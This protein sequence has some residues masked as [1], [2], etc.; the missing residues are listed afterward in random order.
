M[1]ID[2]FSADK[3]AVAK[4][5]AK[6]LDTLY[7]NLNPHKF[8]LNLD[9]SD[10]P[11]SDIDDFWLYTTGFLF[12][13][14]FDE[15]FDNL[16]GIEIQDI[17]N[18]KFII[19]NLNQKEMDDLISLAN[20]KLVHGGYNSLIPLFTVQDGE[21]YIQK[22]Q[23]NNSP[24]KTVASLILKTN[25]INLSFFNEGEDDP[26][27]IIHLI[28]NLFVHETPFV[29]GSNIS[30]VHGG[31]ILQVS[32]MWLR[33]FSEMF[34][35]EKRLSDEKDIIKVLETNLPLSRNY[36]EEQT[37]VDKALSFIKDCF[38]S[39][40]KKN[41]TYV[42]NFVKRRILYTDEFYSLSLDEKIKFIA[43]ICSNNK[44]YMTS[45][46]GEMDPNLIYNLQA[47]VSKELKRRGFDANLP[48]KQKENDE[49]KS[50]RQEIDEMT[51]KFNALNNKPRSLSGFEKKQLS[52]LMHQV[53]ALIKLYNSKLR[54]AQNRR[55]LEST[56][57]E[58]FEIEGLDNLNVEVAVNLVC[59]MGFNQLITSGFYEDL[60]KNVDF[61]NFSNE[62]REFFSKFSMKGITIKQ[63][64]MTISKFS[65]EEKAEILISLR[66]SIVHGNFQYFLQPLKQGETGNYK[67]VIL[68]FPRNG[69]TIRGNL[70]SFYTLF[71]CNQTFDF[72]KR[73]RVAKSMPKMPLNYYEKRRLKI[74]EELG[75]LPE[76]YFEEL[77]EDLSAQTESDVEKN[78]TNI[79]A[80]G[81]NDQF[82]Y[83]Y[84]TE[85][86][87]KD[88][89]TLSTD[90]PSTDEISS[91]SETPSTDKNGPSK[92]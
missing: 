47:L 41:Y 35:T 57:T 62:Q 23:R 20:A 84:G 36:I 12:V 24:G 46:H 65:P 56:Y 26:Q 92:D 74:L 18:G 86:I 38:P 71:N 70:E 85:D 68:E 63:D 7:E 61:N 11:A 59:A 9:L 33:G 50:M 28:R 75:I 14:N 16:S 87:E 44:E 25:P 5:Q 81:T 1:R 42:S 15:K 54:S 67:D 2:P 49:L 22:N 60:L 8:D 13:R 77:D 45:T 31:G 30:F 43:D 37:E 51:E 80:A 83:E 72:E 27:N 6:I 89:E 40:V 39:S 82:Y 88:S 69:I 48:D 91:T 66:H 32:K 10:F 73:L 76:D 53:N 78:K 19:K 90:N 79:G 64:K 52:N 3:V 21:Y 4:R 29:N 58:M 34:G 55:K 17:F